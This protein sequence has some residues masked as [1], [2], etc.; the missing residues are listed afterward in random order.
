MVT[1][2]GNLDIF[3]LP[4]APGA[5]AVPVLVPAPNALGKLGAPLVGRD[6]CACIAGGAAAA[7]AFAGSIEVEASSGVIRR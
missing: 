6:D 3:T 2:T 5:Y 1:P 4:Y 7:F